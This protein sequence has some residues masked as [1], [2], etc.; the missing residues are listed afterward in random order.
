[1]RWILGGARGLACGGEIIG[2]IRGR[3]GLTGV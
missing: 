2:Q 3:D 1:M